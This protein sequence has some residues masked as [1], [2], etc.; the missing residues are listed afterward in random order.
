MNVSNKQS[1]SNFDRTEREIFFFATTYSV[2]NHERYFYCKIVST[3]S[4]VS[5][6]AFF[7][8]EICYSKL[9]L[10]VL[11]FIYEYKKKLKETFEGIFEGQ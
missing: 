5:C 11:C 7:S 6:F 2:V 9:L 1:K 10:F 3:I 8:V 4:M